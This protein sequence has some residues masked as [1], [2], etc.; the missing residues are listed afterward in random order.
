[1]QKKLLGLAVLLALAACAPEPVQYRYPEVPADQKTFAI[2]G[3]E[4][5]APG[6]PGWHRVT[7]TRYKFDVG[8]LGSDDY[9]L[10]LSA[11]LYKAPDPVAGKDW[12]EQ[13]KEGEDANTSA[14]RFLTTLHDVE[15]VKLGAAACARSH[16]VVEDHAPHTHS[17]KQ[18]TMILEV[19]SLNCRHP[20]DPK[21]GV[22]VAYSERYWPGEGD[23][24][25]MKK[26]EAL[27]SS[28]QFTKLVED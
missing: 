6:E 19:L 18:G 26:A 27:L 7:Q 14:P 5:A 2:D 12:A 13:V 9:T 25:F 22:D 24:E 4:F 1:M 10:G 28:V 20:D 8:K 11:S 21:V 3:V 17:G 16:M 23:G 15:P